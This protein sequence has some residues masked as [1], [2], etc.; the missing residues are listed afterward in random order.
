MLKKCL[1]YDLKAGLFLW[2]ILSLTMLTLS[3]P[4]GLSIKYLN[5]DIS[6]IIN[7]GA[8]LCTFV[9]YV[10][11]IAY[12]VCG[13]GL[14]VYRF[15]QNFR[16]DE[17]Y[18]TFTLPVKR[19]TLLHSKLLSTIITYFATLLVIF[20]AMTITFSFVPRENTTVI[21]LFYN[22]IG[23]TIAD[24]YASRGFWSVVYF[25]QLIVLAFETLTAVILLCFSIAQR[26]S[27]SKS[28]AKMGMGR[29][30]L[31]AFLVYLVIGVLTIPLVLLIFAFMSYTDAITIADT[32]TKAESNVVTFLTL[33][34]FTMAAVIVN[35]ILYKDNLNRLTSKLNLT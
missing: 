7:V 32:I 12:I 9:Y 19:K 29:N 18:L 13:I 2:L 30:L 24:A 11:L 1:K 3:A 21:Y 25:G 31:I 16:T 14:G 35:I 34:M 20:I 33:A 28:R 23:E 15:Y 4:A 8:G 10:L 17:A 22:G 6:G 5:S 26:A 27:G